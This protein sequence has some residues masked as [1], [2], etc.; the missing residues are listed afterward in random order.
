MDKK[1]D[2]FLTNE[3]VVSSNWLANELGISVDSAQKQIEAYAKQNEEVE[4]SFLISGTDENGCLVLKVAT[5]L[6]VELLKCSLSNFSKSI[7][8]IKLKNSQQSSGIL[9]HSY[10]NQV[11]VLLDGTHPYSSKFMENLMGSL[12]MTRI[13][14]KSNGERLL[15]SQNSSASSFH[16]SNKTSN[17]EVG[18]KSAILTA[19]KGVSSH[20]QSFFSTKSVTKYDN[21]EKFNSRPS[22]SL[23]QHISLNEDEE[24]EEDFGTK[25]QSAKKVTLPVESLPVSTTN[26][27]A[28]EEIVNDADN[29][30]VHKSKK[31]KVS[32]AVTHGAMDDYMEDIAIERY[33]QEQS[34]LN[35]QQSKK[36]KKV[37]VE[38]VIFPII[39]P[40]FALIFS[41]G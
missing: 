41:T 20:V 33:K 12:R 25:V 26:E 3:I 6:E 1:I 38:K 37:L 28:V 14:I 24:W 31:P 11:E 2:V 27:R 40:L 22:S 34:T 32:N 36:M 7:Y 16:E 5:A 17:D 39:L 4:C 10:L 19:N 21:N 29:I 23:P 30:D 13:E 8:S 15:S 18:S 9:V 35:A